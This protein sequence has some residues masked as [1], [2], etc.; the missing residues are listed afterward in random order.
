M[1]SHFVF[2]NGDRIRASDSPFCLHRSSR[3]LDEN[4]IA[5]YEWIHRGDEADT[6]R[7]KGTFISIYFE[8]KA[9]SLPFM[10]AVFEAKAFISFYKLRSFYNLSCDSLFELLSL[11]VRTCD[12]EV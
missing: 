7:V 2:W 6:S 3:T 8:K 1:L 11:E 9:K 10:L 4:S 12:S 5:N